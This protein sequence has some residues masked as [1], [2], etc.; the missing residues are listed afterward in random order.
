MRSNV[1][2]VPRQPRWLPPEVVEIIITYLKHDLPS[3][4]A[5]AGTC[6]L[7][8][9]IATPRIHRT[10]ELHE[11]F[12]GV[13]SR[14]RSVRLNP[15]SSLLKLELLPFVEELQF[16]EAPAR[17]RWVAPAVF[18][19][20]T[21]RCLHAMVNL[22]ELKISGL[23]FSKFPEGVGKYLGH[24]SP[25]LRSIALGRP[26]GTCR[27]LLDFC[28]LFP[29]LEDIE[30]SYFCA[31][32]ERWKPLDCQP[33]AGR[34]LGRLS[35]D[36]FTEE[37]LLKLIAVTFGGMRFTSMDLRN[38]RGMQFLLEACAN[39]LETLRIY[40][41]HIFFSRKWFSHRQAPC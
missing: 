5:C 7:W 34:L 1:P 13:S 11:R 17:N 33:F 16:T 14:P 32:W 20:Q 31:R 29:E 41:Y 36:L 25:T 21:M 6:F 28:R 40:P 18:N 19:P 4:K 3:L 2:K 39:T 15:L 38:V 35:L 30:I 22:R 9:N 26:E 24:F 27:Q 23:D 12:L 37:E 10:I 8:Y